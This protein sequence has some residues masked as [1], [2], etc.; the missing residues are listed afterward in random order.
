MSDIP[1]LL[2]DGERLVTEFQGQIVYEHLH[3]YA[4]A[5]M[6]VEGKD[7]LDIACGEGYGSNLLSQHAKS[8]TGVD[9]SNKAVA[10]AKSKYK[11]NNLEFAVGSCTLIPLPDSS[12]DVAISF[13]TIEH[14]S[15]H[16]NFISELKRVLKPSGLLIISSPEKEN[17]SV[18]PNYQNPFHIRELYHEEFMQLIC[19]S[20][21]ETA[22]AKQIYYPGS[23]IELE[24]ATPLLRITGDYTTANYKTLAEEAIYSLA[25]A[26]DAQLPKIDSS[27][28]QAQIE[29][30]ELEIANKAN[31]ELWKRVRHSETRLE[32][33]QKAND[34]LWKRVHGNEQEISNL[35]TQAANTL[36]NR[37]LKLLRLKS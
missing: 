9:I 34:E 32:E 26:S 12:V 14:F 33:T 5:N 8:V 35:R 2:P 28:Y 16:E 37:T 30:N 18:R 11:R 7:V 24:V 6:Y 3:R 27:V 20:F 19:D 1:E 25:F 10:H 15:E 36:I 21:K 31:D 13:E 17:Y 22:F 23:I 29:N 4:V